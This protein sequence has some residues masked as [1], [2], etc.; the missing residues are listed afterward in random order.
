MDAA[1]LDTHALGRLLYERRLALDLTLLQVS[2]RCGLSLLA[3]C[4]IERGR[5]PTLDAVERLGHV[6]AL[7]WL[8]QAT[9]RAPGR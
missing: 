8:R 5:P 7:P 6:L 3:L 2:R 1:C 4:E 9:W